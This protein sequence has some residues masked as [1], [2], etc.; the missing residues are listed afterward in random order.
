VVSLDELVH[1]LHAAAGTPPG[2]PRV[3]AVDGR[4]GAGKST[5]VQ[6]L[7]SRVPSS[8]A[9]HTDDIAW[10]HAAFDWAGLLAEHVL[11]PLRLGAAVDHRPAAWVARGRA[12]SISVPAGLDTV[13]VE[14]TGV[15]RRRLL[16]LLDAAVWVQV[17]AGEAQ[18]RLVARDGDSAEQRRHVE[19]WEREERPF[20]RDER[21]WARAT[22]VVAGSQVVPHDPAGE[23]AV[24]GPVA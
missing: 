21:P 14:G 23:A 9:V 18:R 22:L 8:A 11:G 15:V 3:I 13:W 5:L 20:L 6:R 10:H 2:R 24:A 19:E 4:G 7:V 16:P 1:L 12:G 17:D